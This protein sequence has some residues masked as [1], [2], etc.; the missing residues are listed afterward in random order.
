MGT[1]IALNCKVGEDFDLLGL[2]HSMSGLM[3]L[4][5]LPHRYYLNWLRQTYACV[6]CFFFSWIW[7][8]HSV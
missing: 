4:T 5:G 3:N 8:S 7:V 6:D 1:S 2:D